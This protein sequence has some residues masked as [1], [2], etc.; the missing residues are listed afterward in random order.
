MATEPSAV[1]APLWREPVQERS[2]VR[3]RRMLAVAKEL[4]AERGLEGL[5]MQDVAQR[6]GV[7][8]GS[9]YQ[10]F[11][12]RNALLAKLFSEA[13]SATEELVRDRF[14]G[15]DSPAAF[16]RAAEGLIESTHRTVAEDP[17]LVDI[18]SAVQAIRTLRYL[19]REDSKRLA[20]VLFDAAR[21]FI[22]DS[23]SDQRLW[24]ACF[25][26]CQL[27]ASVSQIALDEPGRDGE[28]LVREYAE[29]V[30]CYMRSVFRGGPG[31]VAESWSR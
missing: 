22:P 28:L 18:W 9:L 27:V 15:V 12:D 29:M 16:E 19:D 1:H 20:G 4:I 13:L 11:P 2:R 30:R 8:I 23:V 25:L 3:V 6:S 21:G 24:T 5:R 17:V 10:F 26:T 7:P 14:R 31:E